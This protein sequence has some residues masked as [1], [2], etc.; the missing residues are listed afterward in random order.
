MNISDYYR[1]MNDFALIQAQFATGIDYD[2]HVQYTGM[3]PFDVD[4]IILFKG[5]SVSKFNKDGVKVIREQV[6]E[7]PEEV[8][9]FR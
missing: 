8:R 2:D 6:R 5:D 1:E 9:N 3:K 7:F 4:S